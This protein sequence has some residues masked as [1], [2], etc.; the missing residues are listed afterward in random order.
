MVLAAKRGRVG[1][2]GAQDGLS[3]GVDSVGEGRT[4][5]CDQV[6]WMESNE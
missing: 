5:V 4:C 3:V 1:G 6:W 2:E